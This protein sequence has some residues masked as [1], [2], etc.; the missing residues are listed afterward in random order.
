MIVGQSIDD[1]MDV[2]EVLLPKTTYKEY[3][4]IS[5]LWHLYELLDSMPL[6]ALRQTN[7]VLMKMY[8]NNIKK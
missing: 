5:F 4:A 3:A 2:E 7:G 8:S 1:L 6:N